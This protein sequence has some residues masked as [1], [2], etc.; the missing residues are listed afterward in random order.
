MRQAGKSHRRFLRKLR[1]EAL[2][3]QTPPKEAN[4]RVALFFLAKQ[5][6]V[7]YNLVVNTVKIR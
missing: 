7:W 5:M 6:S 3:E 4:P 1:K 2:N